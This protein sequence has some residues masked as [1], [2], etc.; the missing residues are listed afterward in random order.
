MMDCVVRRRPCFPK[1]MLRSWSG[2]AGQPNPLKCTISPKPGA[3]ERWRGAAAGDPTRQPSPAWVQIRAWKSNLEIL[4]MGKS[5]SGKSA[6]EDS[7]R[8]EFDRWA[9]EGRGEQMARA[10]LDTA[11]RALESLALQ[12]GERALDVGCGVGWATRLMAEAVAGAQGMAAGLDLSPEMVA[13]ARVASREVENAL[14]A[15]AEAAEIPWRDAY[16]HK[17]LSVESFYYFPDQ[18]AALREL[19]RVLLPGGRLAMV[20]SLYRENAPSLGWVQRLAV[21]AQVRSADE[22]EQMLRMEGFD[23]VASQPLPGCGPEPR[24]Y[25]EAW[26]EGW[27]A[28]EDEFREF[29]RI[30]ALLLTARRP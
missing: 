11:R 13:R 30:G 15:V 20:I 24:C 3:S 25:N 21:P 28:N 9:D 14:F 8:A 5:E 29:R 1:V 4:K 22:Y 18:P 7:V 16:F 2:K 12:P 17:A 26:P 10:H 27:F 19:R 23:E 6:R